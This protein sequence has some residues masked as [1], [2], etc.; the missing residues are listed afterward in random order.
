MGS[1]LKVSYI[2]QGIKTELV[3]E[4]CNRSPSL[5]YRC[6]VAFK[7][8]RPISSFGISSKIF[9]S[10][11]WHCLIDDR[12]SRSTSHFPFYYYSIDKILH[13]IGASMSFFIIFL[14]SI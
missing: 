3:S 5:M 1:K 4:N 10:R 9:N 11:Q 14:N 7:G 12:I 2:F 13:T 8:K 6:V